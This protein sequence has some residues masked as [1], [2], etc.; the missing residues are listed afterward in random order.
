ML[1]GSLKVKQRCTL[2]VA[3]MP[4]STLTGTEEM[5]TEHPLFGK[6]AV[7]PVR[8][9]RGD[10]AVKLTA[11]ETFAD[12]SAGPLADMRVGLLHGRVGHVER[13]ETMRRFRA[14]DLDVLV[15]TTVIEVGVDVPNATIMVVLDAARFG[16]A[17]L[18][19]LRRRKKILCGRIVVRGLWRRGMVHRG[20]EFLHKMRKFFLR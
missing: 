18:H 3:E 6:L 9:G 10:V 5:Q 19:Q 7:K 11:E 20:R 14:G 12:L 2:C 8:F 4:S 17:Q 13:E 16:I 15:A 1:A